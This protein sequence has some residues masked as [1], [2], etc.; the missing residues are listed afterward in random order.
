MKVGIKLKIP[1]FFSSAPTRKLA[2]A[3]LAE[4]TSVLEGLKSPKPMAGNVTGRLTDW[5]TRWPISGHRQRSRRRISECTDATL[6]VRI[7]RARHVDAV[8][9]D[10]RSQDWRLKQRFQRPS[11]QS[12]VHC[13]LDHLIYSP[14]RLNERKHWGIGNGWWFN[15]ELVCIAACSRNVARNS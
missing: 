7:Q 12:H 6:Y 5:L 9:W 15:F 14:G 11:P 10:Q 4:L 1:S 2:R 13:N 3:R 8:Q